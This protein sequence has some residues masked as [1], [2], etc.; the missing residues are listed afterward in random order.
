MVEAPY[1]SLRRFA[2]AFSLAVAPAL[3][4]HAAS[5]AAPE[6]PGYLYTLAPRCEAAAWRQG[7]ERFPGG[8][9]IMLVSAPGAAAR[10]LV[11]GWY[12]SA[13]ASVSY[14]ADR[15]LFAGKRSAAGHWQIYEMSLAGEGQPRA[16][17][18]GSADCIR[19]AYLPDRRAVYTR[20]EAHTSAI[21]AIPLAG[22]AAVRL[23]HVPGAYLTAGVLLDGRILYEA[24]SLGSASGAAHHG[25]VFTV[26]SDGTGVESFRCDHGPDRSDPQ[27]L[28]SGDVLFH[29][30]GNRF[31]RFTSAL[32]EQTTI[33]QPAGDSVG[34]IAE[35]ASGVW[36]VSRPRPGAHLLGLF[37]WNQ[38]SG[39]LTDL[40]S[41]RG[42]NAVDPVLIT[43]RVPPPQ[44][45]SALVA[46]RATGN[47]LCLNA[48]ISEDPL[49]GEPRSIRLYTQDPGGKETCLGDA[50]VDSDGSFYIEVP[51]DRP[52]R[53]ELLD[54]QGGVIHAERNWFWMRPSEQRVCVGCHAGPERSPENKVPAVLLRTIVP[55]ALLPAPA[56]GEGANPTA[57]QGV[58]R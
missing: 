17:T 24:L 47:L 54:A 32:A 1:S 29:V 22:G 48:K 38:A 8:A 49:R 11:P 25:E 51:A 5:P 27:Q 35:V 16:I 13:D 21:E 45:P 34:R 26:Y 6:T 44:F 39:Q 20:V 40:A 12:A 41:P 3:F 14:G 9:A 58:T 19:P 43:P 33:D 31:A 55:A 10:K 52:L 23:S 28:A 46:S 56:G 18:D 15:V 30:P 37:L 50:P 53:L 36:I 4:V 7:A 2:M 57:K 42:A